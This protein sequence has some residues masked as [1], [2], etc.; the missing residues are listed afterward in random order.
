[1]KYKT[2][3]FRPREKNKYGAKKEKRGGVIY[4]SRFEADYA[5]E[6]EWKRR[7]GEILEIKRQHKIDIRIN[8]QHWRDYVI[9]FRVVLPGG[10]IQYIE[11]KG[12]ATV[13]WRQKWDVLQIVKDEILEPRAELILVKQ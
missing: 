13:D 9:D 8:G 5:D 2:I 10:K 3:R 12:F 1:M 11:V 7:A 6:L 4:H